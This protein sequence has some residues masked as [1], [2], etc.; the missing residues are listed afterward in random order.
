MSIRNFSDVFVVLL[1]AGVICLAHGVFELTFDKRAGVIYLREIVLAGVVVSAAWVLIRNPQLLQLRILTLVLLYALG[2]IGLSVLFSWMWFEQPPFYGVLEERRTLEVLWLFVILGLMLWVR[3]SLAQVINGYFLAAIILTIY[4]LLYYLSIIPDNVVP[5]VFVE[6]HFF[7]SDDPRS[8]TRYVLSAS[9]PAVVIPLALAYWSE[10]RSGMER[11]LLVIALVGAL[12]TVIFI[13][14]TR[15]LMAGIV[16]VSAFVML[17]RSRGFALPVVILAALL[18]VGIGGIF[19]MISDNEKVR[20]MF[21]SMLH[22]Q[23][24]RLNTMSIILEE[25]RSSWYWG[26]GALSV[27]FNRGF[28]DIYN[29]NFWLNDVGKL[30]LLYRFGFLVVVFLAFYIYVANFLWRSASAYPVAFVQVAFWGY[31]LL[32]VNPMANVTQIAAVELGFLMGWMIN[33]ES[34]A[35][36]SP[37]PSVAGWAGGFRV[38]SGHLA[39]RA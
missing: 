38:E 36:G 18:M 14:Q 19:L 20:W 10:S 24:V 32:L 21:D 6:Q 9:L 11:L 3:P 31:L 28:L 34:D 15:T 33:H 26:H 27:Q 22:G 29:G 4:S 17:Q 7:S 35:S 16:L 25:M 13:N 30:G 1:L 8:E 12:F 23:Q 39:A 2:F 5:D 37:V